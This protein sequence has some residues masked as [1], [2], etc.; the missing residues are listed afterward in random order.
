VPE[1]PPVPPTPYPAAAYA[2]APYAHQEYEWKPRER[3]ALGPLTVGAALVTAG[4]LVALDRGDVVGVPTV[5]IFASTL[6]VVGLG[7]LVGAFFGRARGL[8]GLGV[9]LSIVTVLASIIQLPGNNSVGDQVW[10]PV[11]AA[12]V[13]SSYE[14]GMGEA[15]LDLSA[16]GGSPTPVTT[17]VKLGVGDLKITIPENARVEM[18]TEIGM[19]QLDFVDLGNASFD[20]INVKNDAAFPPSDPNQTALITIDVSVGIGHVEVRR[21]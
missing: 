21:A 19:G 8:I 2:A 12:E 13:A 15:R 1:G 17:S 18:H 11:S 20:G 7:L 4:T 14:W 3:S 5:V 9:L 6:A 16:A 10:K